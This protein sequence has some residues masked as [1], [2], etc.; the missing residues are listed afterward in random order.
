MNILDGHSASEDNRLDVSAGGLLVGPG[1]STSDSIHANAPQGVFILNAE[2]V[3]LVGTERLDRLIDLATALTVKAKLSAGEYVVPRQAVAALGRQFFGM[4]ND[5]G[6]IIRDGCS[7]DPQE[8]ERL[9]LDWLDK[10]ITGITELH[11]KGRDGL[12]PEHRWILATD[13]ADERG[14][15]F[16]GVK[17]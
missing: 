8:H 1:T 7:P 17:S 10:S 6:N 11:E 2:A 15:T 9:L 14:I 5:A 12:S 13:E 3:R 16:P 4:L